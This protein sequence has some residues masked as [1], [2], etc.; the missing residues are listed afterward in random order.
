MT[1]SYPGAF[2]WFE[3]IKMQGLSIA[4]GILGVYRATLSG[5]LYG[6][7]VVSHEMALRV[8]KAIGISMPLLIRM[9]ALHDAALI[10][11]TGVDGVRIHDLR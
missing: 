1:P 8:E 11:A 7:T 5:L 4:T 9:Q 3:V 6:N 2:I 10:R